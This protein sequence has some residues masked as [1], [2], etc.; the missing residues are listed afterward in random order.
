MIER[1]K[2][3]AG[4]ISNMIFGMCS[5]GDGFVRVF[6]LGFFHTTLSLNYSRYMA[7]IAIKN[8]K[9]K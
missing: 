7:K 2:N 9:A 6:S 1:N 8:M 5:I 3:P 4:L